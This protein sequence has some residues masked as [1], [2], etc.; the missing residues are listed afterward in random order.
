MSDMSS[1]P[2]S[3]LVGTRIPPHSLSQVVLGKSRGRAP[4]D[5]KPGAL[6]NVALVPSLGRAFYLVAALLVVTPVMDVL[7]NVWPLAFGDLRWRYGA[8][9][10]L[11]GFL[12]TTLLGMALA[13]LTAVALRHRRVLTVLFGLNVAAAVVLLA[14]TVLFGLDV[15]QVRVTVPMESRGLFDVGAAKALLK[16]FTLVASFAALGVGARSSMLQRS[17]R[18][19]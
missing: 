13:V 5:A 9:G 17:G 8:V 11:S 16:H 19:T 15:L 1:S 14:T 3:V 12:L 2:D 10:L 18:R 6:D 7:T 4:A